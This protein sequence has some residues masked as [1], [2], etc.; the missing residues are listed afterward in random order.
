MTEQPIE[1]MTEQAF[2]GNPEPGE[3]HADIMPVFPQHWPTERAVDPHEVRVRATQRVAPT[4]LT[5]PTALR[6][7]PVIALT[8]PYDLAQANILLRRSISAAAILQLAKDASEKAEEILKQKLTAEEL[9]QVEA[10]EAEREL[11]E[12][13]RSAAEQ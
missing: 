4:P 11:L 13:L 10:A 12:F 9:A 1:T 6:P 8:R 5:P 3:A 7:A 2:L